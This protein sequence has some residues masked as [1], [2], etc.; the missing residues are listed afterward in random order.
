MVYRLLCKL[1]ESAN[2][3]QVNRVLNAA[4]KRREELLPDWE[5]TYIALPK[6]DRKL[7]G[8]MLEKML[9][10]AEGEPGKDSCF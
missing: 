6:K 9:Q 1:L 5:M 10:W 2:I 4:V 3:K 8:E 7:R